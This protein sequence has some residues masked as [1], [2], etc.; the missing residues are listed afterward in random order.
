LAAGLNPVVSTST[1]ASG[2]DF[3]TITDH[4]RKKPLSNERSPGPDLQSVGGGLGVTEKFI[5]RFAR[6]RIARSTLRQRAS[7]V[8]R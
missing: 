6:R 1:N 4:V 7:V 5:P 2:L 3:P 8:A